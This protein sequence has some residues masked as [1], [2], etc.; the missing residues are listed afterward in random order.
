VLKT[1]PLR[2]AALVRG[3]VL[4]PAALLVALAWVTL[5]AAAIF[6]LQGTER[7]QIPDRAAILFAAMAVTPGLI[8]VQLLIQNALAVTFPAWVAIGPTRRGVDVMGQRMLVVFGSLLVVVLAVLP[9]AL[10]GGVVLLALRWLTG[11]WRI[12][13]PGLV[14]AMVL[15]GEAFAGSELVGLIVERTDVSALD[16][17]DA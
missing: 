15:L 16:P 14:A 12:A 2:G 1:W 17:S 11:E 6:S 8:L 5:V 9:A 10:V 7:V 4:A 13:L 3:E